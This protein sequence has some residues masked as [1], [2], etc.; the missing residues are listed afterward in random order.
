[1]QTVKR[2]KNK[3]LNPIWIYIK[4]WIDSNH[5]IMKSK[6]I[7]SNH[8]SPINCYNKQ[9]EKPFFSLMVA[10]MIPLWSITLNRTCFFL[11]GFQFRRSF[12]IRSCRNKYRGSYMSS[13]SLHL[14]MFA[15]R[16]RER[17][18]YAQLV[19][20]IEERVLLLSSS[21]HQYYM[22]FHLLKMNFLSELILS[23]IE[24][25]LLLTVKGETDT[26]PLPIGK[27]F[28][29][30]SWKITDSSWYVSD[31]FLKWDLNDS[32]APFRHKKKLLRSFS[33]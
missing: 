12:F 17:E 19:E 13:P 24:L 29:R 28:R 30:A 16:Y 32:K 25:R 26:V 23:F 11:S 15:V 9:I 3:S 33:F 2:K 6:F 4:S 31:S 18:T 10:E 21:F 22:R 8:K 14:Y 5:L 20:I 7:S 27:Q 1:M